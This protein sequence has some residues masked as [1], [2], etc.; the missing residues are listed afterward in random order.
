M[1]ANPHF[2]LIEES[3]PPRGPINFSIL[4]E[5]A[6][7]ASITS[8]WD[9]LLAKS[10]CN[11][12]FNCSK[13]YLA[14]TELAPGL[15]PLVFTARRNGALSGLLPLWLD[16]NEKLATIGDDTFIDHS[17]IIA[18]DGDYE[19]I[20]GLLDF[21]LKG[22]NYDRLFL[23]DVK[24]DSNYIRAAEALGLGETLDGFL[25]PDK[26]MH[27]AVVDLTSGYDHYMKTLDRGF[28]RDLYRRC[29]KAKSDGLI[30]CELTPAELEP[31]I[32]PETFLSLH[33]SRFGDHTRIKSAKSWL[34][35]LFPSLFAERRMRVFA[36]QDKDRI[37]AIDLETVTKSG[38]YGFNGG[39]LPRFRNYAPGKLLIHKVIQQSCMEGMVECDFGWWRQD[40]KADW[41]PATREVV[42]LQFAT[43]AKARN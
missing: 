14:T 35:A 17:D 13:W 36:I 42:S 2:E 25:Q 38:M 37:V 29:N 27:H 33:L 3:H 1:Q 39:F 5:T 43:Y 40:Y 8:E 15:Q 30:V 20:T 4:T 24:R 34:C 9:D 19:V 10:R 18:E 7:V 28:R 31:E 26:V 11:L 22:T 12:A 21:A 32:L 23:G 16:E 6:Q 41:K